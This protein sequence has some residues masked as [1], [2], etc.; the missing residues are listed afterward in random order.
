MPEEAATRA[1]RP[2]APRP[3]ARRGEPGTRPGPPEEGPDAGPA[4]REEPQGGVAR[5][6]G[7]EA[8]SFPFQEVEVDASQDSA[9]VR[10]EPEAIAQPVRA[11]TTD[12]EQAV[13]EVAGK[14]E[15]IL[16]DRRQFPNSE[17]FYS[18]LDEVGTALRDS[19]E[20]LK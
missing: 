17:L 5:E 14:V 9:P 1:E 16:R 4:P 13:G 2:A 18:V 19:L 8:P 15:S 20:L 3:E 12:L 7:E 11:S 6:P 10:F